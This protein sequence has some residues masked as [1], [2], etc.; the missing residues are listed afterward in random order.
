MSEITFLQ[1][2]AFTDRPFAGNPAAVCL[3]DEERDESWMQSVAEEMNLSETAFLWPL[4]RG[5]GL[6]WFTPKLEVDL[7]GHATL[8]AAHA[9]WSE[10]VVDTGDEITFYTA[11]GVLSCARKASLIELDFPATPAEPQHDAPGLG[12]ALGAA[13]TYV[14]HSKFDALVV[15]DS[16]DTVR[17]IAPDFARLATLPYRG[18]IVT[19]TSE[20]ARFDFVS[21]FFAPNA[22]VNEDPVTGSAHCCLGPYWSTRLGKDEMTAFQASARGGVVH[23]RMTDDRVLLGGQA[24]TV[25]RGV[26]YA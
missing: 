15:V 4:T 22:G 20:D 5:F 1:I 2:D 3:L 24:V 11:S 9:L 26:L 19:S 16:E 18:V 23:L 7:C 10:G 21:R 8:A 12:S 14:G 13:P 17:S 6:R 25:V